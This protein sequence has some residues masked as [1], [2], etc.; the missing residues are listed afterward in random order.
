MMNEIRLNGLTLVLDEKEERLKEK[1]ARALGAAPS[2]VLS[3]RVVKKA[4]DARRSK[5]PR[6]VYALH[7]S[8]KDHVILPDVL[9]EGLQIQRREGEP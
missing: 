3:C 6:F 8:L 5:P 4:L 2:D 9:P 1:A 7:L